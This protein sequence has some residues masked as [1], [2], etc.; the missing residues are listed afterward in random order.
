MPVEYI[1]YIPI[2]VLVS[3]VLLSKAKNKAYIGIFLFW[4]FGSPIF[5]NPSYVISLDFFGIDL[6][7]NRFLFLILIPLLY[8]SIMTPRRSLTP[9]GSITST[10]LKVY[11]KFLIGYILIATFALVLN[12]GSM[13]SR[14]VVAEVTNA[15][16]FIAVYFCSKKFINNDDF[17]L[18]QKA[19]LTFA[20]ISAIVAVYQFF[21]DPEFLRLG[22]VRGAF[23]EYYRSNGLFTAEYDQGLFLVLSIIAAMSMNLRQWTKIL[24]ISIVCAGIFVTMHRLS[25]VALIITLGLIWCFYLRKNWLTN[26][27]VPLILMIIVIGALNVPWS[28]MAIGKFGYNLVTNRILADTL[29]GRFSQY[30]FSFYLIREYPLGIGSY[31]ASTYDQVAYSRGMPFVGTSAENRHAIIVHNGFLSAGVKYGILGLL[32]FSLF[33]FT[34]ILHFLK[35][36]IQEGKNWYPLLMIMLIF[37]IFNFTNDFSFLGTQIGVALAW[38]IGGYVSVNNPNCVGDISIQPTIQDSLSY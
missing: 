6:Q 24:F 30:Q 8:I 11:E 20:V 21:V 7:P 4:L 15:L 33:I 35:Y 12:I 38:L 5:L 17:V 14:R 18:F 3:I 31:S 10:G 25:W 36:S 37:P 22:V 19:I 28:Q 13:G 32:L 27:F 2:V 23:F 29:S 34:S 9:D 1:I 16:T 26:T